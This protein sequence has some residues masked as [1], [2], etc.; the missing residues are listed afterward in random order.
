MAGVRQGGILSPIFYCIYV[1]ELVQI[2]SEAGIG[3]HVRNL[4]LSILLYA[5]DMCLAAPSLRGL[6]KLLYLV[7]TYCHDWDIMLNPKK[8]N[9]MQFGKKLNNLPSLVLDGKDLEW[10]E[11]WAYL[12][13]TLHS[14]KNFNCCIEQKLKKFLPQLK[15]HSKGRWS[16]KRTSHAPTLRV[17]LHLHPYLR[18][19]SDWRGRQRHSPE[20]KGGVQFSISSDFPIQKLRFGYRSTTSAWSSHMGRTD[21]KEMCQF[22]Y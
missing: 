16:F 19:R 6:Q 17:S 12:G 20:T 21:W 10:V 2:L 14:Y 9:N 4:F 8:F 7:E 3:C 1:D 13:F 15:C 22:P 5:D 18:H 11:K